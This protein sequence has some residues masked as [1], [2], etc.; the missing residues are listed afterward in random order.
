MAKTVKD[1][2]DKIIDYLYNVEFEKMTVAEMNALSNATMILKG[3]SEI[4]ETT[5]EAW[6]KVLDLL[7][8]KNFSNNNTCIDNH[9]C[10]IAKVGE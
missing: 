3:V 2:K 7:C 9:I 8:D 10:D 4:K 6:T 1:V 5:D